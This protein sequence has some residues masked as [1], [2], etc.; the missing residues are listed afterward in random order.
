MAPNNEIQQ[1]IASIG[2]PPPVPHTPSQQSQCSAGSSIPPNRSS[3]ALNSDHSP[4]SSTLFH[5]GGFINP[6]SLFFS[7]S[8]SQDIS[9]G[10][11]SPPCPSRAYEHIRDCDA[12]TPR[13]GGME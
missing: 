6:T 3:T 12:G 2:T 7:S 4:S 11:A 9:P 10:P 5:S 8:R 1:E 13:L